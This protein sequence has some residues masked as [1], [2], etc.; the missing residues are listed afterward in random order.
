MYNNYLKIFGHVLNINYHACH[1]KLKFC[2]WNVPIDVTVGWAAFPVDARPP[3]P[4]LYSWVSWSNWQS[5]LGY[6]HTTCT[7]AHACTHTQ[8]LHIFLNMCLGILLHTLNWF[9]KSPALLCFMNMSLRCSIIGLH[10]ILI[11]TLAQNVT[12]IA[13]LSY[14]TCTYYKDIKKTYT[15]NDIPLRLEP[16]HNHRLCTAIQ[17]QSVSSIH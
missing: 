10:T 14:H 2:V 15:V 17:R 9:V 1:L 3:D 6:T 12:Y 4:H 7:H 8:T 13:I 16:H 5:N 11:L